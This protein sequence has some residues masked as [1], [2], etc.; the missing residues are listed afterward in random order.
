[1]KARKVN[2]VFVVLA[3]VCAFV[4]GTLS[5]PFKSVK[6]EEGVITV[7]SKAIKKA[8][9]NISIYVNGNKTPLKAFKVTGKHDGDKMTLAYVPVKAIVDA[10][11]GSYKQKGK[12]VTITLND[13]KLTFTRGKNAY[14]YSY[15][16]Y[17]GETD[18]FTLNIGLAAL[19]N[20]EI[21]IPINVLSAMA[22]L[23]YVYLDSE[24]KKKNLYVSFGPMNIGD[25]IND[26]GD[27]TEA[28]EGVDY[29]VLSGN[30]YAVL[31]QDG[32]AAIVN[33]DEATWNN[34][35][36]INTEMDIDRELS[37]MGSIGIQSGAT[38]TIE[39]GGCLE[40]QITIEEGATVIV[41]DGG[42]LATAMGNPEGIYNMGTVII[43]KGGLMRS[44]MGSTII[45]SEAGTMTIDGEFYVGCIRYEGQTGIWFKNEGTV[46]GKGEI[47]C[48]QII[49]VE[50]EIADMD[51][52]K[53]EMTKMIGEK[54][55]VSVGIDMNYSN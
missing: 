12:K 26:S 18:S 20:D 22:N 19:K 13:A 43:E 51:A 44:Q 4:A 48:Y 38:V 50:D 29:K 49:V 46:N 14:A 27:K 6:A 5:F 24:L 21:Y 42:L 34:I 25:D 31:T 16:D 47:V 36:F 11:G 52:C 28:V 2:R 32:I 7:T 53:D 39:K 10:I 23:Q 1:M 54:S 30:A 40:G 15:K 45:N 41:K 9:T 35:A 37:T 8:K 3:L 55:G 17:E 33:G